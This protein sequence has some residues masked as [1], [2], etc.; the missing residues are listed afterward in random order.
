[1]IPCRHLGGYV[2]QADGSWKLP[3]IELDNSW[4][5]PY[6]P[7]L[8][9]R[10]ES[11]INVEIV[12]AVGGLKYLFKYIHKG[13]DRVLV[14]TSDG[15]K[16]R[17]EIKSYINGRYISSTESDWKIRQYP[18]SYIYP[19]VKMLP[20]HLPEE[21]QIMFQPGDDLEKRAKASEKTMLTEFFRLNQTDENANQYLYTEILK[22]YVWNEKTFSKRKNRLNRDGDSDAM[23][24]TISRMAMVPL[25]PHTQER[26][27]L[28]MLL[29]HVRGPK[30]YEELRTVDGVTYDTF[31]EAAIKRR[32]VEDDNSTE[33]ALDEA[34]HT[35]NEMALEEA[36]TAYFGDCFRNFFAT[37][38]MFG[39]VKNA[40]QLYEKFKVKL[41]EDLC[42]KRRITEPDAAVFN[43]CLKRLQKVFEDNGK[44]MVKDFGLDA[45]VEVDGEPEMPRLLKDELS[46]DVQELARKAEANVQKL[47][48]EQR[49]VFEPFV[50][51]VRAEDGGL[52][53]LDAPAGTGKTYLIDC[54]LSLLRSEGLIA[55][56]MATTGIASTLLPNGRTLH[57]KLKVPLN[58][59]DDSVI[60]YKE[61]SSFVQLIQ[62]TRVIIID[63]C[64]M[65]NKNVYET[66]DRSFRKMRQNA[67]PFGGVIALFSGDWR[68]CLPIVHKGGMAEI[69]NATLKASYLWKKTRVFHL[70]INMRLN[71][72]TQ[73]MIV[74]FSKYLLD[75]GSGE[76]KPPKEEKRASM[77]S[78]P[79]ELR[80]RAKN[81]DEF[82]QEIYPNIQQRFNSQGWA[83]WL[84]SKA[85]ICP[86]NKDADEINK[87]MVHQLPGVG[88]RYLSY[89]RVLNT[90][91]AHNYPQEW[92]N[93]QEASSIPP[94]CLDLKIGA[95]IMLIRNLDPTNGHVNGSRYI[96]EALTS[97]TIFGRLAN[98]PM[99]GNRLIIPRLIFHPNDPSLPL[100]F[101]RKQFP[102]RACF[103]MTSN[104]S[105]GQT[106]GTVGIYLPSDFFAHGQLYVAMSRVQRP[107]DLRFFKPD[108][109]EKCTKNIVHK[110]IFRM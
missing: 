60:P 50:Q 45:P 76:E 73:P 56:A 4:V 67:R 47:N 24:D 72:R 66:I 63:E 12:S 49:A 61:N 42:K 65:M 96:I 22:H 62:K 14:E 78:I 19:P 82:C 17:D 20:F 70:T 37:L 2:K 1:M 35:A 86:T 83:K 79:S 93:K 101:E 88:Q 32:L 48:H 80:S 103:A 64:T 94:H 40:R 75:I 107:C 23:S 110:E 91:E 59:D 98:G 81:L 74:E 84:C 89:D 99:E 5:V 43:E 9:Y 87:M 29:H 55:L 30:S 44:D 27:Y 97:N 108:D 52:F 92:L 15:K 7:M 51:A 6:N 71:E 105:Q 90:S 104:K 26:F 39:T 57:T 3:E 8:L 36:Y 100:E 54:I 34:Y 10:Y 41:C 18:I 77:I 16:V 25:N 109:T 38:L 11:H 13:Q 28:R 102:I 21:Q 85:I 95:P 58:L 106:I 68:Q 46:Y 69:L 33:N 53:A 31:L